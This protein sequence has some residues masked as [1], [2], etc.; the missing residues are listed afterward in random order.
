MFKDILEEQ[1]LKDAIK[2]VGEEAY[3]DD[4]IVHNAL[5]LIIN[6]GMSK[7]D[8]LALAVKTLSKQNRLMMKDLVTVAS[9]RPLPMTIIDS[10]KDP[11]DV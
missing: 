7:V 5:R 4:P 3:R 10:S 2:L 1:E 6:H 8:A 11:R 9:S